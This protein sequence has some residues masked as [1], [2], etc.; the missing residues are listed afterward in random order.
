MQTS[1]LSRRDFLAH[2]PRAGAATLAH[3]TTVRPATP[4]QAWLIVEVGWEHN[5]EFTHTAGEFP[6]TE[7]F[8]DEAAADSE[9]RPLCTEF[10]AAETPTE[11]EVDF[12]DHFNEAGQPNFDEDAVTWE[13]LRE[14]G[15][16]NPYYVLE[17]GASELRGVS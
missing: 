8:F 14:R 7:V 2:L 10:F 5:D 6:R 4:R 15:F 3:G 1:P 11:F 17:L 9:C 13:A 12:A 16:P